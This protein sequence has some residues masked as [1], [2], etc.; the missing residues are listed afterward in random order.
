MLRTM[1][2][3]SDQLLGMCRSAVLAHE[4]QY[5]ALRMARY[6]QARAE[7]KGRQLELERSTAWAIARG[8]AAAREPLDLPYSRT[9]P[10][11]GG[12]TCVMSSDD[13]T[14]TVILSESVTAER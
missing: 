1:T 5:Y 7:D 6:P 10:E 2:A 4:E 3:E 12:C 8:E 13:D 9:S 11:S 14:L